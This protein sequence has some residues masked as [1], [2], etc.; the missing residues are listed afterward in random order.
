[1]LFLPTAELLR[2]SQEVDWKEHF[3]QIIFVQLSI[4]V[5]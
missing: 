3:H 2:T 4:V 1:M 5:C